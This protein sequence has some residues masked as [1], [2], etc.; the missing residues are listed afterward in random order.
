MLAWIRISIA[1]TPLSSAVYLIDT[2]VISEVRKGIRANA[3][4]R[5]FFQTVKE[6]DRC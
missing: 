1:T 6:A 4:V 3:G 5:E 2:N